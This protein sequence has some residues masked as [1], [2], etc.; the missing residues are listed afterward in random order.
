[1]SMSGA[2]RKTRCAERAIKQGGGDE[3]TL[4]GVAC[5]VRVSATRAIVCWSGRQ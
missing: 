4:G 1:M 2:M 3:G 5:E